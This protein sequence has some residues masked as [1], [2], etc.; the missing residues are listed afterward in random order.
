MSVRAIR[1]VA[2][3]LVVAAGYYLAVWLYF[4]ISLSCLHLGPRPQGLCSDW[5]YANHSRVATL[6]TGVAL[7]VSAILAPALLA[8]QRKPLVGIVTLVA[9]I[10]LTALAFDWWVSVRVI[11]T[12]SILA[13]VSIS[14]PYI[15]QKLSGHVA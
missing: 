12:I 1:W 9:T 10:V 4:E 6:A 15:R 7:F 3:P 11:A 8:P 2:I 5:W 13:V 14:I